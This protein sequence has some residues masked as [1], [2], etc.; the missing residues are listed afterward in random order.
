VELVKN[1]ETR[2]LQFRI[3]L[4]AAREN[5]FGHNFD[6]GFSRN[7]AVKPDRVTHRCANFFTECFRHALGRGP[8]RKPA[9]F[10]HDDFFVA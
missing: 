1:D 5:A 10:K 4:Q 7:L 9:R 8:R 2:I 3:M 6:A